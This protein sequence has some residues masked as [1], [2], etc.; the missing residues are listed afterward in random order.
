MLPISYIVAN[1]QVSM[2]GGSICAEATDAVEETSRIYVRNQKGG[3]L[4]LKIVQTWSKIEKAGG[5][6]NGEVY[7]QHTMGSMNK[8]EGIV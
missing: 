5:K 2:R 6:H 8:G 7:A 4:S 3:G 1:R